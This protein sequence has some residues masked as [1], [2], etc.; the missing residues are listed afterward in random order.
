M[1]FYGEGDEIEVPVV[2]GEFDFLRDDWRSA[3]DTTQEG[4]FSI[5]L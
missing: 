2:E 3:I 4:W 1:Y 5:F